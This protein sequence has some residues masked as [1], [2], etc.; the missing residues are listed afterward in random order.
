MKAKTKI[1]LTVILTIIIAIVSLN[2]TFG[3][4]FQNF[5][6][7]SEKN[8]ISSSVNSIS[9]YL[10]ERLVK[11]TGNVNDWAHWD[12]T[13]YFIS[14]QNNEFI[15]MNLYES[16]YENLDLSF[17]LY[18]DEENSIIYN[19]FYNLEEQSFTE[20]PSEFSKDQMNLIDFSSIADDVSGILKLGDDFY[21]VASSNV[22]DSLEKKDPNGTLIFGRQIDE[23]II[24]EMQKISDFEITDMSVLTD[25]E[26]LSN[27]RESDN[28]SLSYN[29]NIDNSI[30]VNLLFPNP[31][32]KMSSLLISMELPRDLYLEGMGKV[33][34]FSIFNTLSGLIAS[35]IIF[36]LVGKYL[37]KPFDN[38]I[39]NVRSI[40]ITHDKFIPLP[41]KGND[42]FTF[43][44]KSINALMNRIKSSQNELVKNK[45]ELHTT[46]VS[47]GEGIIT[48]DIMYRIQ[49]VNQVAEKLT[50]CTLEE[51]KNKHLNTIFNIVNE[52]T[53]KP[54]KNPVE[55]VFE[56][57]EKVELD[58]HMLLISSN[59]KEIPA[60][61]TAAPIKD[62][63]LKVTGCVLVV[64]D[65]TEKKNKQ[66]HIEYLS[67]RDYLTGLYNRRFYEEKLIEYEL[68]EDFPISLIVIDV[69]G[70]KLTNDAFGHEAG[71][72][73]LIKVSDC[74]K[75]SCIKENI[76]ARI[77]GDEFVILMS[78]ASPDDAAHT[79]SL[80]ETEVAKENIDNV[81]I[82]IS[83]GWASVQRKGE[84]MESLFKHAED[85]MYRNKSAERNSLRHQSIQIIR[86]TLFEKSPREELHSKRVSELCMLIGAKMQMN[87]SQIKN[88]Q[89][90]G[91]L[92]DIGKIGISN[93]ILD[94][95]GPLNEEE[96]K[97]I[98]KHPEI[99]YN[100][101]SAVND[102]G[103]LA[104]IILSHHERWD[105]A[106]YPNGLRGAEIPL[107]SRII[108]LAD[109]YDAMI[110]D[111]PY[112]KGMQEEEA[113]EIIA[114]EAGKQFDPDIV[115]IFL[116]K[117]IKKISV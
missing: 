102:Y 38:L 59:G 20:F 40:D 107:K 89:I 111:R 53:R 115:N 31:Y 60:E 44:S 36:L 1:S 39:R 103:P 2:I 54:I 109:A 43:L 84:S 97:E 27:L 10:D 79:I 101:L 108:A 112:R 116:E 5:I 7:Q 21:F 12:D 74:I 81:P 66:K 88:L 57:E 61:I 106:G 95:K 87:A 49:F 42:E 72:R 96:W 17:M 91:L 71:D 117:V 19:E 15:D 99:S 25:S 94:K 47:I 86:Q 51:T 85:M 26:E 114:S 48:V 29:E 41:E 75:K 55:E 90:A 105:G 32:N 11:L 78:N 35:L 45:E 92:H 100:I 104:E 34:G 8:Q 69:N 65:I 82:S 68:T 28:L 98:K 93:D 18:M 110:S 3:L 6:L 70:L 23:E 56:T 9:S 33:I 77:G 14:G 22:T 50:G 16:S 58:N 73:L 67:Y 24:N 76:M 83:S 30:N 13:F 80:I 37:S 46:L 4:F 52:D 64:R 113:L 63:E 62:I